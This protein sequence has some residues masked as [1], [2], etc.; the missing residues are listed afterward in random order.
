MKK[1]LLL[2]FTAAICSGIASAQENNPK[3]SGLMFGDYFYNIDSRDTTKQDLNGFQFRRIYITTD[4]AISNNFDTRFRMEADQSGGSL[5]AGGKVGVMVKDVWL[6]WKNIFQGSDFIFGLSPTPAF[7][8]SE[9]A[10]GYRSLEKTIMDFNGVVSSRDLGVDLKGKFNEEGTMKYW[11]KIGNNSGNAP[12]VNKY[13]RFYG[14]L[15]FIPVKNFQFTVYGDYASNPQVLDITTNEM[16]AHGTVTGAVMLN[17]MDK[18]KYSVGVESFYR[19]QQNNYYNASSNSLESQSGYGVSVWAWVGLTDV[20]RIVGRFD[21]VDP[22]TDADKDARN[23][24]IGALDF[25]VD[26]NVSI[27]PNVEALTY[28][29]DGANDLTGRVTL[30]YQF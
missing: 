13:K 11:V 4:Y 26:K 28:Q 25:R 29:S 23:L 30:F 27:M 7:D 6:R 22:N 12:E 14:L 10:W 9:A 1:V 19:S 8:V 3:F 15:Q 20:V 18:D 5:T 17:V 24:I 16:K 2:L 21:T